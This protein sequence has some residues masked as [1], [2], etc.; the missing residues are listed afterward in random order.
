MTLQQF[1][2]VAGGALLA[3]LI[4]S[5]GLPVYVKW[6]LI[7]ISFLIGVAFAFFPL[8]DRPLSKWFVL[9]IKAIY[10]PTL[11]V[12]KQTP[13]KFSYFQPETETAEQQ[14]QEQIPP[15]TNG[16]K[17]EG[18]EKLEHEEKKFLEKVSKDLSS[19]SAQLKSVP[20]V[21]DQA[22]QKSVDTQLKEIKGTKVPVPKVEQINVEHQE[23]SIVQEEQ[24]TKPKVAPSQVFRPTP[25][26]GQKTQNIQSA[27]FSSDA[28]PPMPPTKANVVVGQVVDPEGK[29]I[30][31]A[32]LEIRDSEG[33]PVR[34]LKS[35]KLGHFMIVTPLAN[36]AYQITTEKD[37]FIFD[38]L[39][40]NVKGEI[41]PP[42]A[43][44]AKEKI[45][46]ESPEPITS[47]T[48]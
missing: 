4:Y 41:I 30:E 37:G 48:T 46:S 3:L 6:P 39:S 8:E 42:L 2:Q 26:T 44:W 5:S 38:T 18:H 43:V 21:T 16:K 11:Y 7:V 25:S 22:S 36:G 23:K 12:W 33:R 13:H 1:F 15:E 14:A 19:P 34:A 9:F 45:K 24:S 47:S 20:V 27:K 40:L 35:N 32:I 31:N 17:R 28:A 29:I 10:S